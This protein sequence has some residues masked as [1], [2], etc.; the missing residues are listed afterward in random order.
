M[1]SFEEQLHQLLDDYYEWLYEANLEDDNVL[2]RRDYET[3]LCVLGT[4]VRGDSLRIFD[5]DEFSLV[6]WNDDTLDLYWQYREYCLIVSIEGGAV[7]IV[8]GSEVEDV[9]IEQIRDPDN[10]FTVLSGADNQELS[11]WIQSRLVE[12]T[13]SPSG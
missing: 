7:T 3:I 5:E 9:E 8:G 13:E 11:T 1:A 12:T 2:R 6:P 10:Y 4:V